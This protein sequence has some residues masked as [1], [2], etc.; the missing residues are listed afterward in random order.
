[1]VDLAATIIINSIILDGASQEY[2]ASTIVH[3]ALHAWL[4][5]NEQWVQ[6][7]WWNN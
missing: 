6:K 5:Y 1:M 4:K 3:K 7:M 2:T